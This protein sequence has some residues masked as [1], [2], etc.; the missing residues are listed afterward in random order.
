MAERQNEDRQGQTGSLVY[1]IE[2]E[3]R[4]PKV[5]MRLCKY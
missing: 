4:I 5:K 1:E 3:A 2:L